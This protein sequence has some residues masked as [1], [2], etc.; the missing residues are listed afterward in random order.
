MYNWRSI[1]EMDYL[2]RYQENQMLVTWNKGWVTANRLNHSLTQPF[3]LSPL[4]VKLSLKQ[5]IHLTRQEKKNYHFHVT[6]RGLPVEILFYCTRALRTT[7]RRSWDE[8]R[9]G[10]R[11]RRAGWDKLRKLTVYIWRVR[12]WRKKTLL[13]GRRWSSWRRRPS[14]YPLCWAATSLCARAWPPRPPSSFTRLTTAP[15]TTSTLPSHT[16]STDPADPWR[17][18]DLNEGKTGAASRHIVQN[19]NDSKL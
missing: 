17:T 14:I 3:T 12:T 8:K 9:T 13:W 11:L 10:L 1:F 6:I 2:L 5:V 4:L 16:T 19:V 18:D 15:T 7:L